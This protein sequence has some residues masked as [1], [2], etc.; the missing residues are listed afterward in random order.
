MAGVS[1]SDSEEHS[2]AEEQVKERTLSYMQEQEE[3]KSSFKAA[4]ELEGGGAREEALLVPRP[5]SEADKV[6]L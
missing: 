5:K 1:D 6:S 3:L 2:R 4:A